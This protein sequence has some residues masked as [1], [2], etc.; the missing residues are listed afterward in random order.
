M[1][2]NELT[3]VSL[4]GELQVNPGEARIRDIGDT[5]QI[6]ELFATDKAPNAHRM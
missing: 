1:C 2:F 4:V 5:G 3:S 6:S